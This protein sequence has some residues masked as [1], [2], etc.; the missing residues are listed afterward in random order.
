MLNILLF[1]LGLTG[2]GVAV[3]AHLRLGKVKKK[4][5]V[6]TLQLMGATQQSSHAPKRIVDW[7]LLL[8]RGLIVLLLALGF[9]KLLI[10][11]LGHQNAR[12]YALVILDNSASMQARNNSGSAFELAK[13]EA[14]KLVEGM[15]PSSRVCVLSSPAATVESGWLSPQQA[16]QIIRQTEQSNAANQLADSLQQASRRFFEL[17]DDFPKKLYV[18]SDFQQSSLQDLQSN[19]PGLAANVEIELRDIQL[20]DLD[21]RGLKLT[22]KQA[23]L[24]ELAEIAFSDEGVGEISYRHNQQEEQQRKLGSKPACYAY[25]PLEQ[26]GKYFSTTAKIDAKDAIAADNVVYDSQAGR[27]TVKALVWEPYI[28]EENNSRGYYRSR[29]SAKEAKRS[30]RKPYELTGYFLSCALDPNHGLSVETRSGVEVLNYNSS[31]LEQLK[32]YIEEQNH[33]NLLLFVP[34]ERNIAQLAPLIKQ[35]TAKGGSV[36][37]FA[38]DDVDVNSYRQ[39]L[40]DVLPVELQASKEYVS[41]PSIEK[42]EAGHRLFGALNAQNMQEFSNLRFSRRI[43]CQLQP[44]AEVLHRFSDK[45]PFIARKKHQNGQVYFINSSADREWSDFAAIPQLYVPAMHLIALDAL[46]GR[47]QQ[48]LPDVCEAG[49]NLQLQFAP[50]LKQGQVEFAGQKYRLDQQAAL[51]LQ[52]QQ[53]GLHAIKDQQGKVLHQ[54]AVNFPASESQLQ[55]ANPVILRQ[56]IEAMATAN[57]QAKSVAWENLSQG[58]LAWQI[59]LALAAIL[60]LVEPVIANKRT[61]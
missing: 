40:G 29:M 43:E 8:L 14:L 36:I 11:S 27:G 61:V 23:G 35:L 18:V 24:N 56:S 4:R 13:A 46:G 38:G 49:N 31:R 54:L 28:I 47:R 19:N 42:I 32:S 6:S 2:I 53:P 17:N 12:E 22:R 60:M 1:S 50:A 21:N 20:K 5:V 48:Q 34:A 33:G 25:T 57:P 26:F 44:Q 30:P 39:H 3:W 58:D 10:A 16:A 55:Y 59:C 7:P 51:K 41:E 9:G 15:S 45:T 37:L 52:P